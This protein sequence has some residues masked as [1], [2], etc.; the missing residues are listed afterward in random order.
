MKTTRTLAA[1]GALLL[2]GTAETFH[3]AVPAVPTVSG[4]VS[5]PGL[6]YPNPPVNVVPEAAKVEDF[7]YLTEEYFVSGTSMERRTPRESLC[8]GRKTPA[9][10]VE[11]W[12]RRRCTPAGGLSSLNG[13]GFRS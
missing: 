9:A 6:M 5:G 4:P 11:P 3:A 8:G 13:R 7:P 12:W 10:S 2:A 1:I